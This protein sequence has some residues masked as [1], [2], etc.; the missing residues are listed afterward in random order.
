MINA[1]ISRP[2]FDHCVYHL[3]RSLS[4]ITA[5]KCDGRQPICSRCEGYGFTCT[6]SKRRRRGS[7]GPAGPTGTNG[8]LAPAVGPN[9]PRGGLPGLSRAIDSYESLIQQLRHNLDDARQA[10]LDAS[11]GEIRRHIPHREQPV[12]ATEG[13]PED[14]DAASVSSP[15]TYLGKAS[16]LHFIHSIRQCVQG[17]T[18]PVAEAAQNYSQTH[19]PESL[20]LFKYDLLFPSP[21]EAEQFL[22]VFLSTIHVAYPFICKSVLLDA[23]KKFQAGDIN[24]PE[25]RPWLAL[26]SMLC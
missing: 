23:F 18:G 22:D 13:T 25:F 15:P 14:N 26:L 8:I 2:R 6:W 5:L 7:Q 4:L 12:R 3:P 1:A 20:T 24:K 10:S 11:L 16:D 21:A 17:P 19:S 9:A